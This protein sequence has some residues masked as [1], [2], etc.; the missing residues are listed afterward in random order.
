MP[1]V[2]AACASTG[3][4]PE[5]V[6]GQHALQVEIRGLDC[7]EGALRVALFNAERHWLKDGHMIRG[8]VAPVLAAEQ[9]I[10]FAGLPAGDYAV[11]VYQDL[12]TNMRLDR[13]LGLVPREPYGFSNH[14]GGI[15]R[16]SFRDAAI[17]VTGQTEI[18][19]EMRAPPF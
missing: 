4:P 6:E 13:F 9:V 7:C 2:L 18:V 11:A 16:P 3:P 19:I 17:H 15:G 12:N 5:P 8:Q 14:P 10:D 1:L